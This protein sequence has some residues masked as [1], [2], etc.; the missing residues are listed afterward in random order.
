MLH[1]VQY[2]MGVF[3]KKFPVKLVASGSSA[4]NR[5]DSESQLSLDGE[6]RVICQSM[7]LFVSQSNFFPATLSTKIHNSPH[8][9]L[10]QLIT[11][12]ISKPAMSSTPMKKARLSLVISV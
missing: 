2:A 6:Y 11:L 5:V 9:M 10:V 1:I 12:K 4:E 7:G 8:A 3:Y